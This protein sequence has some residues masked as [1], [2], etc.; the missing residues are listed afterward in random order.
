MKMRLK[1]LVV[2]AFAIGGLGACKKQEAPA[3]KTETPAA[4][5]ASPSA[6]K[7]EPEAAKPAEPAVPVAGAEERAAKLG[8]AKY[9]PKSVESLI[10]VYDAKKTT[11]RAKTLKLWK[12]IEE[13]GGEPA[14]DL[15]RV[16]PEL[17]LQD[18]AIDAAAE[19]VQD[20][21]KVPDPA[22]G[23]A[24]TT[25]PT[26][27]AEATPA[28]PATDVAGEPGAAAPAEDAAGA[29]AAPAAEEEAFG[30][31]DALGTEVTV[32]MGDTSIEQVGNLL[33]LYRRYN[34]FQ[35]RELTKAFVAK[36]KGGDTDAESL[37]ELANPLSEQLLLEVLNDPAGGVGLLEKLSVPPIYI[38]LKVDASKREEAAQQLSGGLGF[39]GNM[40]VDLVEPLEIEKAGG[41]FTGY[42]LLGA[43]LAE[44]LGED[45]ADMEETIDP[46]LLDR[47][48]AAVAKRDL[49]I[50]TGTIGDYV[51]AFIGGS[52]DQFELVADP[53]ESLLG[54]DALKFGDGYLSKDLATVMF[55]EKEALETLVNNAGG[56]AD[57]A[58]GVRDGLAGQDGL[59]DTREIE[60]LLQV[61]VEREEALRKLS[62]HESSTT[63]AFFEE[64]LKIESAGGTDQGAFD[65]K[66]PT[67]LNHLGDSPDVVLFADSVMSDS[68]SKASS[69]FLESLFETAYA[70]TRKVAEL[71]GDEPQFVQFKEMTK[72]FDEKFRPDVVGLWSAFS[73]DFADGLGTESALVVDLK[74]SLPTVPGV[75]QAVIDQARIPR[76][77]V[78]APVKDR[79]KLA[80]AWDKTNASV[81][82]ILSKVGEMQGK[83]IPMQKPMSSEK[84][85]LTTWFFPMPFFNDSFMPSVTVNDSW[86]VASTSK[87]Q[88]VDLAG[89]AAQGTAG[90]KGLVMKVNFVALQKYADE[91]L[92]VVDANAPAIFGEGTSKLE[93][94]QGNKEQILKAIETL[95]DFDS[96]S[97]Y[98]NRDGGTLRTSVHFKTR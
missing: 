61:V 42:K 13:V 81:T 80:S 41:K 44:Q 38:A 55:G 8:F 17:E 89:K 18:A 69:E 10:S 48:F 71:P 19:G 54:G 90:K 33:S 20:A 14:P 73:G 11:E 5:A 35:T 29:P 88:A 12:F 91:T 67:T 94:F 77:S 92:K 96:L 58:N 72:L 7:P 31:M 68:Y 93:E 86:F 3:P 84:N 97:V 2:P 39:V 85:G 6:P 59:G 23:P 36:A 74:G 57:M 98:S 83:E 28:T 46:A 4:E 53:K 47:L 66:T 22:Q 95:G 9:L 50:L 63:V 45:R 27:P 21:A 62:G 70:V 52:T 34:Y 56:L 51:V 15:E 40:M 30:P 32:A 76:A 24:E 25:L 1:W 26:D 79:A 82:S 37:E 87:D 16:E 60:S 49:V 75:P 43:K 65:W 78:I 64:G